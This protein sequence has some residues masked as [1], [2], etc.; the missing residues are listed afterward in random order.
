MGNSNT[1]D[2]VLP[3]LK[4]L[5]QFEQHEIITLYDQMFSQQGN[6]V[7]RKQHQQVAQD[8]D[9]KKF[10]KCYFTIAVD[11]L[12]RPF[13]KVFIQDGVIGYE[14]IETNLNTLNL[15]RERAK[16]LIIKYIYKPT[17]SKEWNGAMF[18]VFT[19][20][21]AHFHTLENEVSHGNNDGFVC[22]PYQV[23]S[24]NMGHDE[25]NAHVLPEG[26]VMLYW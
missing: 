25:I 3:E 26:V 16:S 13:A 19:N 17:I 21:N 2:V 8:S 18:S 22:V 10:S 11:G 6:H 15:T 7:L 5:D 24:K 14:I 4:H 1:D 12:L 23:E 9:I 20:V